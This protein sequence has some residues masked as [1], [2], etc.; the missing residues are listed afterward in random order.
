MLYPLAKE[1]PLSGKSTAAS[2][3]AFCQPCSGGGTLDCRDKVVVLAYNNI[4]I[5]V[6]ITGRLA[7]G[8]LK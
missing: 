7:I 1:R 8:L 5:V 2:S 6:L 4:T 3:P